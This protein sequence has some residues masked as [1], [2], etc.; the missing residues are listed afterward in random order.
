MNNPLITLIKD[1]VDAAIIHYH[2]GQPRFWVA[3]VIAGSP[4]VPQNSTC[5]VYINADT[6]STPVT[7]KNKSNETLVAGNGVYIFS[8]TGSLSDAVILIKK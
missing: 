3:Q 6:S 8:P 1:I 7:I 4:S 2:N 5:Q